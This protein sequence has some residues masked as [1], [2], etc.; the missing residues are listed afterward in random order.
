MFIHD[1]VYVDAPA[2]AVCTR[3]LEDHGSWLGPL[4]VDATQEGEALRVRIGPAGPL[5][6]L[7]RTALV[8]L[9]EPQRRGDA[10]VVPLTWHASG[11]AAMF[12]VL[13]ADLE[14]AGLGPART[15]LSVMGRYD[16][17]LGGLGRTLDRLLFHRVAEASVRSF[18]RR[19][20]EVL[21]RSP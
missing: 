19:V 20:A 16:P 12:P 6:G 17:P 11:G 3:I 9:G 5:P 15:Q 8:E 18:L 10:T 4:A 1:F 7:S 21:E 13:S 2:E 14:V